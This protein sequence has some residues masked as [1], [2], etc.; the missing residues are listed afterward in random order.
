M[1]MVMI[2]TSQPSKFYV[3]FRLDSNL[4][5]QQNCQKRDVSANGQTGF[6]VR[7]IYYCWINAYKILVR[8]S[9]E[10]R[11][12]GRPRST[13]EDNIKMDLMEIR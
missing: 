7:V 13:G 4:V 8:K 5:Q 2:T 3:A 6:Y 1:I 12:L 10:K 9:E 11:Q